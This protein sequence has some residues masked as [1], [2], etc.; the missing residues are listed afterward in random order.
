MEESY[1]K[2]LMDVNEELETVQAEIAEKR[3]RGWSDQNTTMQ[4]LLDKE[5]ELIAKQQE[6]QDAHERA[7]KAI[8]LGYLEQ[9]MAAD[10]ILTDKETEWLLAKG[11][12]WGIYSDTAVESYRLAKEAAEDAMKSFQDKTVTLTV[13]YA[14]GGY[15]GGAGGSSIGDLERQQGVDINGNGVIG[16]A[17]GGSFTVGGQGGTDSQMVGFRA[18][19]G[20]MVEVRQPGHADS[21]RRMDT[22]AL[23][24]AFERAARSN[25]V[26]Y[27]QLSE[28]ISQALDRKGR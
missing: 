6:I 7:T 13:R 24:E 5:D 20:E 1:T 23:V 26:D 11:V 10:G 8:I 19:P 27:Q 14:T 2:N 4:A 12:E 3:A 28:S 15:G 22:Q 9:E 21:S 18:T 17:S 16:M 25:R